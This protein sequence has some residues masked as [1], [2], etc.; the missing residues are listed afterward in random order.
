MGVRMGTNGVAAA[1]H[2]PDAEAVVLC[3]FDDQDRELQRLP[4][5][6]RVGG[7][8][9]GHFAGVEAGTR[10]GLRAY[11]PWD[12][13]NGMRF[14]PAKLLV[15]PWATAIDRPFRLHPSLFDK[16]APNPDDT[17]P[18][19]PKAIVG[20]PSVAN[21]PLPDF[22]W[23][24]QVIYE[25][26]VKG[27]SK[28]NPAIPE[29]LRGT[30]AGL[31]H[32]ASIA[33]LKR[34]GVT[35]VELMPCAAWC[36][37][38][39]LPALNLSNYWGY[40]PM[41]Y[42][43]PDPRLAPGGWPEVQAA[44]A[45]LH[46]AG[47]A[48]ILDIV[49]NHSA[50]S[51]EFG[52][53]LS[54][55]GLDNA[56]Y[57]RLA[58][59]RRRYVNDAGC[60][61]VLALDRPMALRLGMDALRAWAAYGG[62]D[63]FRLDLGT[64]LGRGP[65]GFD[66]NGPFLSAMRQD[67][68]LSR[69]AIIA[70]PWD[71][72]MGGY[73]LGRFPAGWGE[74]NDRF[75]DSVRRFWRGDQ[76]ML[77]KFTTCFAG[78]SDIFSNRPL[79]RG[80]N[81]V[82]AHDG[83]TLADLVSY[84]IKHNE[85]N[86]E[87]NRDGSDDNKS[88]NNGAE[89]PT[90]NPAIVARRQTD[91]HALLA[92]LLLSR[93]TPMLSMGDEAGRT[94]RG[95]N[96]AYAQD[97]E[98]AWFDWASADQS[99]IDRTAAL[100]AIR[101]SLAP[102][103][104][105]EVLQA[106]DPATPFAFPVVTWRHADG[107]VLHDW[108]NP[109]N[110]TLVADL[111]RD[112]VRAVLIF[113]A[114]TDPQPLTLPALPDGQAW[115]PLLGTDGSA[116][117]GRS[118]AVF[119]AVV[120]ASARRPRSTGVADSDVQLLADEAGIEPIWWDIEGTRHVVPVDTKRAILRAMR[121]PADTQSDWVDSLARV[122]AE[123]Q[124]PLPRIVIGRPGE[125]IRVPLGWPAP[126]WVTLR[127]ED[128]SQERFHTGDGLTLPPQPMG[129]HVLLAHDDPSRVCHLIVAPAQ[130]Y[131]PPVL[132]EG[133]RRF[134]IAAHLYTLRSRGDQGIGDFA[135]LAGLA[136]EA[137]SAGASLVGLNPLH[138]MFPHDRS[139]ASP[140]SPSDRRF[141]DP[142]YIDVSGMPGGAGLPP[143]PGPVDYT[144]VWARKR[145]VL[146]KAFRKPET[147][148]PALRR[149]A[150][151]QAIA[152][153]LGSSDWHRWPEALRHPDSPGVAAFAE[154]HADL[155]AF[156]AFL[157][158]TAE[159]QLASAVDPGLPIGFYRDLA[160]GCAP[161]GAEAWDAQETLMQGMSVGA[162]PDPFAL[163]GQ[164][165]SLPPPD[166]VAMRRS[167]YAAF[168]TLLESNMRH[169]GALRIDHAIGLQRL[170]V[171]PDGIPASEGGYIAFRRDELIAQI[172]LQ[173]HRARCLVVGEDLGTV[174]EGLPEALAAANILS[175]SVLWFQRRND[176]FK[177]P[178]T[179]PALASACVSTHDL[180]TLAGW[181]SGADIA[182]RTALGLVVDETSALAERAAEKTELVGQL[183]AEGL[184][185]AAPVPVGPLPD[186]VAAATHGFVSATPA[187]LALVQAD[188]LGG[189][190]VAVNLPGT[191]RE[192]PNWRRRL[193]ADVTEL[194]RS[195]RARAILAAMGGRREASKTK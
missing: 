107:G 94:Q 150:A 10:Y 37:E 142:I 165:W 108:D 105:G 90:D 69:L 35:T 126:H 130:C 47:I 79:T 129:R 48:V 106:G 92:T 163:Q 70:E 43:A 167:G 81:F 74:W 82:T 193:T 181:W 179:W 164:V 170:F 177:A 1:V 140:Y 51:D 114:G 3:L 134:G 22:E 30:F 195:D 121:L 63:G 103:F 184:L 169:A 54:L 102:I 75:R 138:A 133:H 186:T 99:L 104:T 58:P 155:V 73:Q 52:P 84:E 189:E 29:P 139:R 25:L 117:A 153:T 156:H 128:G 19:V 9:Q 158:Q 173:S 11:G 36:D 119:E 80:I 16:D 91:V 113:H 62:F 98:S 171:V 187:L 152:E 77:G 148:D 147:V 194:C 67:P 160:V 40:N 124:G 71:I 162:P 76:G 101:K 135:T 166:P 88:W 26:H 72:G 50:E 192:R 28:T 83:F 182:E 123:D 49:L 6:D 149:F 175:Y 118:V 55:R 2:A 41:A 7:V 31:A 32:P 188:D 38:R 46:G 178:S 34:L 57:Y 5:P 154:A 97:N 65:N 15:D 168:N 180:P 190:T 137:V 95:N 78:S 120:D 18:F 144:A 161:D 131:L 146:E 21:T 33:H 110:R 61:N 14:N 23:N 68:I 191:D 86:G 176:A 17:A 151:Y 116:C 145:A 42:L 127:R 93:G 159:A 24:R 13:G 122:A 112:A 96:N 27:F 125:P 172:A 60:G 44:V 53:T 64:T 45:A 109:D 115:K 39:H 20:Q 136:R 132:A 8:W 59:D 141:L 111:R 157:Q 185:E 4:L 66:P 143:V 183:A 87:N 174:P 56:G 100:I 12:P 89:G 85:A